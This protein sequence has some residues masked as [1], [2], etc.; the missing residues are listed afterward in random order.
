MLAAFHL[1]DRLPDF[2]RDREAALLG[3][4]ASLADAPDLSRPERVT[5]VIGTTDYPS[6]T[7]RHMVRPGVA[8][9]GDAA[10]VGDPLNGTGCGW[11]FQ[12][13]E[14]LADAVAD[15]LMSGGDREIDAGARRYER[16]HRRRLLP[17][18]LINIA[19]SQA[20]SLIP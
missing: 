15:A 11:A 6:I 12:S 16:T 4:F 10:M 17:H 7:R 19:V 14:W 2:K 13:A 1:K 3:S 20:N 5:N 8:L 18:Q 9:V